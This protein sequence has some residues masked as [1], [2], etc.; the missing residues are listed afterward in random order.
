MSNKIFKLAFA[1]L[2][3]IIKSLYVKVF[4]LLATIF[5]F[6]LLNAKPNLTPIYYAKSNYM[7]LLLLIVIAGAFV[8]GRDFTHNTYT[9]V[10]TGVYSK[11]EIILSKVLAMIEFGVVIWLFQLL[12]TI[13]FSIIFVVTN[14]KFQLENILNFE[15][16]NMLTFYIILSALIGSFLILVASI[17]F[18]V[19]SPAFW[20]ISIFM[21]VQTAVYNFFYLIET[22][23]ITKP[24]WAYLIELLPQG[25]M[26]KWNGQFWIRHISILLIYILINI[27]ISIIV[28][29]KKELVKG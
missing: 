6:V 29:N 14:R 3:I 23:L 20:G 24:K 13:L 22:G 12:L 9:Y 16:L 4:F 8:L 28:I 18:N 2:C 17:S 11:A 25:V 1:D 19:V 7:V 26:V 27:V 21:I 10:F 15:L 5:S